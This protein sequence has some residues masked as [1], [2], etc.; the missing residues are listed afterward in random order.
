MPIMI[1]GGE[2]IINGAE[3][4]VVSQLHRSPGVDFV[5][6]IAG[7]RPASCTP[8]GSSPS[9]AAGSRSTSP[10]RTRSASASTS[11]GKFS[12]MTLLRAMSPEYSTDDGDPPGRSTTTEDGQARRR[13]GRRQA[14]GHG[15]P[16][17]TSSTRRPARSCIESGADDHQEPSA[18]ILADAGLKTVEVLEGRQGPA[19]PQHRCRR[20][21]PTRPRGGA[22]QDLP[23]AA[24]GQPA[25]ARKGQGAVQ[26]E[27]PRR[28]PLPPRARSAASAST[29]SSTRTSPR[30]R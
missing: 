4:V 16:S 1:G 29:A 23:A 19:D 6:E 11:R 10:R 18:K 9:A 13:Q 30:P 2:F 12:A 5:V 7:R 24:P 15:S 8:A 25:A 28:Q 22:A 20:T 14:R 17:A 21:R 3:R 26:R 27:V